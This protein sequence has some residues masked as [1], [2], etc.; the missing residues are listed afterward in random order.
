MSFIATNTYINAIDVQKKKCHIEFEHIVEIRAY[1]LDLVTE[2][3][4]RI[5]IETT[6]GVTYQFSEEENSWLK[7]K[8]WV[9]QFAKLQSNWVADAYPEPFS[10]KQTTLWHINK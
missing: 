8:D 10:E 3:V 6:H 4:Q 5:S 2:D 7:F 9:A 1:T